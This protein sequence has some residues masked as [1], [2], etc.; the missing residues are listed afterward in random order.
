MLTHEDIKAIRNH[1]F[2]TQGL[3]YD[4]KDP[5][6]SLI[7]ANEAALAG[8]TGDIQKRLDAS[9]TVLQRLDSTL[10][11]IAETATEMEA[12]H[13]KRLTDLVSVGLLELEE[14]TRLSVAEFIAK[15]EPITNLEV[16][17]FQDE[18]TKA[19]TG[20]L[21]GMQDAIEAGMHSAISKH[22]QNL[23]NYSKELLASVSKFNYKIE[24]IYQRAPGILEQAGFSFVAGVAGAAVTILIFVLM[25]RH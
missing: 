8:V 20:A 5:L 7:I 12:A 11:R 1:I 15:V 25:N 3:A 19:S 23:D 22:K 13:K 4:V 6:F 21:N 18:A 10:A 9:A 2:A 24:E 14:K 16:Q 17:H